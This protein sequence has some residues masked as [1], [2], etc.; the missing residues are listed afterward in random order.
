MISVAQEGI[1]GVA[2]NVPLGT[3]EADLVNTVIHGCAKLVAMEQ[4]LERGNALASE[5]GAAGDS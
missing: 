4:A 3:S 5:N 2:N 1:W